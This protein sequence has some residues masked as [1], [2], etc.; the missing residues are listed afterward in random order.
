MHLNRICK[1]NVSTIKDSKNSK[2]AKQ[3]RS[4]TENRCNEIKSVNILKKFTKKQSLTNYLKA[5][6]ELFN[7]LHSRN[8]FIII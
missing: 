6:F 1:P 3:E 2:I 5:K 4:Q 7:E 8:S